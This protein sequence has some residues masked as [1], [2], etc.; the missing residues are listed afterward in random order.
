[1]RIFTPAVALLAAATLSAAPMTKGERERLV[2]HFEMTNQ[3]LADEVAGLSKAQLSFRPSDDA[4]SVLD[5]VEHLTVAEPQY[6]QWLQD[7][8]KAAPAEKPAEATDAAILWYGIDRTQRSKTAEA[9][10]S[11]GQLSNLAKGLDSFQKLRAIMLDYARSTSD[12]LRSRR[13]QNSGTDL[14]QWLLMISSHSQRHILQIRE[15]KH[16]PSFP[17]R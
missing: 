6:W 9:R 16:H 4:W 17:R 2:A 11:K 10:A 3:W 1:M 8:M 14:Y 13:V 12:D 15:L 5:I 7:G